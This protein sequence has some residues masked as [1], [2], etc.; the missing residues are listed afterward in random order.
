MRDED[1]IARF[2]GDE[3]VVLCAGVDEAM[4]TALGERIREAVAHPLTGIAEGLHVTASVGVALHEFRG[5]TVASVSD[6][7]R[8]ADS[9]MYQSKKAG[10][11]RVTVVCVLS[12]RP[13][14]DV[15]A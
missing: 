9:A 14:T 4:A 6:M 13:S 1:T 5:G 7:L 3:F 2:G 12:A 15:P 10:K 11:N 8:S